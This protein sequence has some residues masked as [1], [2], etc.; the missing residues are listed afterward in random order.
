MTAHATGPF[1]VTLSPQPLAGKD[2]DPKLSRMSIEKQF[3]G[4]LEA[5]SIGEMLAANT[6][7]KGAAGY[8]AIEHVTGMLHGRSGSFSLQHNGTLTRGVPQLTVAVV[9]DSGAGQLTGL[10][11]SM[12]ITNTAGKHTYDFNYTLPVQ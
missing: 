7:V 11:G 9:P 1:D 2:V 8:V 3:H 4:G 5:T 12:T 6:D 10:S